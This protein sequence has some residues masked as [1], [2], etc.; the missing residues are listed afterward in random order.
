MQAAGA[1]EKAEIK[2]KI[3]EYAWHRKK[4]GRQETTIQTDIRS[5]KSLHQAGANLLDSEGV[6]EVL[7]L[8]QKWGQNIRRDQRSLGS[9]LR[10]CMPKR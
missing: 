7:A 8:N 2:E 6:K 10:I 9:G 1:T 5:I 3:L 4:Q